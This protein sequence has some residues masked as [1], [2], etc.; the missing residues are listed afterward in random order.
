[1]GSFDF[2]ASSHCLEHLHDPSDALLAWSQVVKPGGFLIVTVPDFDLYEGGRW[3]SRY[4]GDHKWKFTLSR[5]GM[6]AERLINVAALLADIRIRCGIERIQLVRD[7]HSPALTGTDQT[8]LPNVESAIEFV[9]RKH[10]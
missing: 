6:A 8:L 4:N 2:V 5:P 7:F 1:V 3:P 9:L 10:G